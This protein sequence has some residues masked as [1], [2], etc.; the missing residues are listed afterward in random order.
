M[1][2]LVILKKYSTK[3]KMFAF[4]IYI[5]SKEMNVFFS[6]MMSMFECQCVYLMEEDDVY[7]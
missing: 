5:R 6:K 7:N 2:F 3:S 1:L 4:L